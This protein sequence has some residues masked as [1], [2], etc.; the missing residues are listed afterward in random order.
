MNFVKQ[1]IKEVE[2]VTNSPVVMKP[3]I[4]SQPKVIE[5]MGILKK[6]STQDFAKRTSAINE[7]VKIQPIVEVKSQNFDNPED[8]E[9]FNH[10]LK[11]NKINSSSKLQS[12]RDKANKSVQ[13]SLRDIKNLSAKKDS[14]VLPPYITT[15]NRSF[16]TKS[17]T[18]NEIAIIKDN[19]FKKEDEPDMFENVP[20]L[21]QLSQN[22]LNNRILSAR[23]PKD[24]GFIN[25]LRP[26]TASMN[27]IE[28]KVVKNT[29]RP[30]TAMPNRLR[31][32][33][34]GNNIININI[35]FYN[36]DDQVK[37]TPVKDVLYINSA[38]RGDEFFKDIKNRP[39][40]GKFKNSL[41]N[42]FKSNGFVFKEILKALEVEKE[43]KKLTINDLTQA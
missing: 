15:P 34:L 10:F 20:I 5:D 11:N 4:I 12:D 6:R 2:N 18:K 40:T 3:V 28:N 26:N 7:P 41:L 25:K 27:R 1:P 31:N 30:V 16:M 24:K 38:T 23:L 19:S 21:K 33:S 29:A 17:L 43:S 13:H 42:A 32:P 36:Y 8:D 9:L 35:N 37:P 39:Q 22:K 14:V